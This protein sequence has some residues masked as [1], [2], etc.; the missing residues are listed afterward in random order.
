MVQK[1]EVDP[2]TSFEGSD[3]AQLGSRPPMLGFINP[4]FQ[5]EKF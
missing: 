1:Q 5:Y 3:D 4:A 2:D